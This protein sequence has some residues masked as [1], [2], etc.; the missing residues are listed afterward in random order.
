MPDLCFD[1]TL[2]QRQ[3]SDTWKAI[4]KA[5]EKDS[6]WD[7]SYSKLGQSPQH[8]TNA[9]ITTSPFT[10]EG[11]PMQPETKYPRFMDIARKAMR[12][13]LKQVDSE[14]LCPRSEVCLTSMI[15]YH[16]RT[17]GLF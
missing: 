7:K 15:K 9:I 6:Y 10:P 17:A 11:K 16:K 8:A 14:L 2:M 13:H 1:W 5:L 4:Y 3:C 12:T